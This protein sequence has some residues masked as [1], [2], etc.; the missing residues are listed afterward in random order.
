MWTLLTAVVLMI[1]IGALFSGVTATT[2]S[3]TKFFRRLGRRHFC[4]EYRNVC[5]FRKRD[6][7]LLRVNELLTE[8]VPRVEPGADSFELRRFLKQSEKLART[9]AE[10]AAYAYIAIFD[11]TVPGELTL[12]WKGERLS[13]TPAHA[14]KSTPEGGV[15]NLGGQTT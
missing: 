15:G 4:R 14:H 8:V 2:G 5:G 7:S 3:L 13:T 6:G 11:P 1:G 10:L 9:T 12:Q